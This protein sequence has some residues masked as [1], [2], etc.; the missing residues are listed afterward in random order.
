MVIKFTLVG[1]L[2]DSA[3]ID[4]VMNDWKE[5]PITD[6]KMV[7]ELTDDGSVKSWLDDCPS[8]YE[9]AGQAY[10]QGF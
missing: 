6:I 10:W 1:D 2:W 9:V 4:I 8:G 3:Y 5:N 7:N